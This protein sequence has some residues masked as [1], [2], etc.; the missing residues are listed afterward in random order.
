MSEQITVV[1]D[2][3]FVYNPALPIRVSAG[4][5]VVRKEPTTNQLLFALVREKGYGGYVLPKGGVEEGETYEQ[6]AQREIGEEAGIHQLWLI[7]KLTVL[8]RLV[9]NKTRWVYIH[10]Y[11][12]LTEQ[13]VFTPSDPEHIY[14][15]EWRSLEDTK[16][17]FWPDQQ[18]LI[19]ERRAEIENAILQ[20]L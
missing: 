12:Y 16:G 5:V 14:L 4:G 15:P 3:Y 1:D 13:T 18:K 20:A 6:A 8:E 10:L 7:Q 19:I 17:M 9:V 11:L 2:S